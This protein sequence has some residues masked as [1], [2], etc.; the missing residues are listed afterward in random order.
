MEPA[1]G[2]LFFLEEVAR[3][4]YKIDNILSITLPF[5]ANWENTRR[6]WISYA[7]HFDPATA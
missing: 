5:C 2:Q 4:M 6:N 1:E 7:K 3:K